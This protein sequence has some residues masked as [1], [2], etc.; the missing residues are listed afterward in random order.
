MHRHSGE[1]RNPVKTISYWMPG[2]ARHDENLNLIPNCNLAGVPGLL[3]TSLY[4]ALRASVA[5]LPCS[6]SLPAILSNLIQSFL[7]SIC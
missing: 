7:K 4:S 6:K 3:R 1:S 2:Q 5:A